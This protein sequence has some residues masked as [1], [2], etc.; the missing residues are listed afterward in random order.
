M[1]YHKLDIY[2]SIPRMDRFKIASCGNQEKSKKLYQANLRISQ[3]FYPIL[4]LTET[5]LRNSIYNSIQHYFSDPDWIIIEKTGFMSDDSL[6]RSRFYLRENVI[7]AEI[8][9]SNKRSPVTS[10]RIIAEQSFGFW[11][12]LLE[13]QHY[14]LTGGSAI[15]SFPNKPTTA[16]RVNIY[17]KLC[18]IRDFRN[19][20]YHNEPICFQ[21][22][23]INFTHTQDIKKQIFELLLW[24]D[25]DACKFVQEFDNIDN[26]IYRTFGF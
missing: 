19:R 5:F 13:P 17:N 10:G 25:I 21:G 9:I 6:G 4:N 20:I 23:E 11:V 12:S 22:N 7:K 15:Q 26:E 8:K 16:G 24:M 1:E 3:A 18:S 2:I 14:R